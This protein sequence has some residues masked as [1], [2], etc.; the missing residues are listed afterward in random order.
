[1]LNLEISVVDVMVR[2]GTHLYAD[3][4]ILHIHYLCW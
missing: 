2:L 1:M 3:A 4:R